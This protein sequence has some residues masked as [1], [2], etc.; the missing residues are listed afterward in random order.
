[1]EEEYIKSISYNQQEIINNILLLYNN[2]QPIDL[3]CTYSKGV[4]YKSNIVQE[5]IYKS[6][7]Y[8]INDSTI[9]ANSVYLPFKAN[10]LKCIIFDPPF[11]I[12][13]KT[14]KENKDGSSI[15]AK[16]F[17]GY[18]NFEQLKDHYKRTIQETYRI[19]KKGGI[20]I[21]KLQ[22]TIS[23]SK[24]HFTHYYVT[25][26]AIKSGFYPKDEFILL[27]KSKITSFG[28]RWKNQIHALKYHSYFLVFKK[29]KCKVNYI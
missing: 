1:M 24:Q 12:C 19:L 6:D 28:G 29:E 26:E 3:D 8:S 14:Y 21:F 4:F 7:L 13:G 22:N 11:I 25:K 20:L 17:M 15:I 27:S 2:S 5:P 23:S 10:T 9:K 16:R 18:E